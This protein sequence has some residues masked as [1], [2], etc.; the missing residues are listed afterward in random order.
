MKGKLIVL[1]ILVV[2]A[3]SVFYSCIDSNAKE[4]DEGQLPGYLKFPNSLS[5]R[6]PYDVDRGLQAR[7]DGEGK[8]AEVQRMFEILSWQYFLGLNWPVDDQGLPLPKITDP[9]EPR[10]YN[11]KESFEV[12]KDDGSKPL[13]WGQYELPEVVKNK[14]GTDERVLFRTSKFSEFHHDDYANE[15]DQAFTSPIYDQSGNV[16]RYEVRMNQIE[17]DY[18]V[19]NELY[20]F[21]GQAAFYDQNKGRGKIVN[22]PSAT[23]SKE[24]VIEIKIAWKIMVEDVDDPNRYYTTDAMVLNPDKST[25][26]KAT[27]GMIGMHISTKTESSPQW[28]WTTFEHVDNLETN[29]LETVNGHPLKPSFNDPD[30]QICPVNLYPIEKNGKLKNQI[31]RIIPISKAT[32]QLNDQVQKL[33]AEAGSK[34]QYYNQVGTQWPTKPSAPAYTYG[35]KTTFTLPEAITNKS[36]GFPT[37]V[38]L[39]N[40]IM[41]TYFQGGTITS[42]N[43]FSVN[44]QFKENGKIVFQ[45]E[46]SGQGTG[47]G[48][49]NAFLGNEPAFFQIQ[50]FP[51]SQDIDN[52]QR[53]IFGTESCISCHFSGSIATKVTIDPQTKKKTV[54]FGKPAD[55]DF[56]W[57]LQLK[58]HFK[59]TN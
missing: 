31:Q 12:F 50:G 37:P 29:P 9:G 38:Y 10:W 19:S 16:V 36:G 3:G 46:Y 32:E 40:M 20:N 14:V 48:G 57:L 24:G 44:Q 17:F 53:M 15:I 7:L 1:L 30:C 8:F 21:E 35:E 43:D 49:Y 27:V 18:V 25:Y 4:N 34:F 28:I 47:T 39:T 26:S 56:S 59:E 2:F 51:I 58:A 33:L 13:P 55:A 41:E 52:T 23:Q 22:F 5:S 11:W 54:T 6:F 45:K 42:G